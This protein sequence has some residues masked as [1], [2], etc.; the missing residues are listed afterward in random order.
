V[1]AICRRRDPPTSAEAGAAA[2]WS[3]ARRQVFRALECYGPATDEL[4]ERILRSMLPPS[5]VRGARHWLVMQRLARDT[6]RRRR[7]QSGQ[8]AIVWEVA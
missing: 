5:S 6:G 4:L 7:T 2:N 8:W 1:T 3:Y